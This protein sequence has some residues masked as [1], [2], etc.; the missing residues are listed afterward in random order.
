[1]G[2][3][4][5]RM[6]RDLRIRGYSAATRTTY[7]YCMRAYVRHFMIPP[8]QLTLEQVHQFQLHLTRDRQV[9][10]ST[11]NVHVCA[12]RFFY[13]VTL[14]RD[15]SIEQIPYQKTGRRLPIVLSRKEALAL[16][17]AP[18]NLKHR[19]MLQ[20][21]YGSGLR[22]REALHLRPTDIDADRWVIRVEQ[23]KGRKDRYVPLPR[24]FLETLRDY[25]SAHPSSSPW[26]FPGQDTARPLTR[27]TLQSVFHASK[28]TAGIT[29]QVTPHSLRHSY[30]T[31]LMENGHNLRE[32]QAVLGHRSLRTTEIYIHLA[33]DNLAKL[34]SPLDH[35]PRSPA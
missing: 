10:W 25:Q 9:A 14:P 26:L 31:H 13:R 1:M 15:W 11:F 6:D 8:D 7:L 30:A 4:H 12:L 21:L 18:A 28:Q 29:K 24:R 20:V 17:E 34:R 22:G 33:A 19:A 2:Y 3:F 5:D 16:V 23:G 32:I 35:P 27:R